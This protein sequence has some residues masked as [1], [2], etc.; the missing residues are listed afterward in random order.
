M[1]RFGAIKRRMT[2]I[3][4]QTIPPLH[5]LSKV[6]ASDS[7]TNINIFILPSSLTAPGRPDHACS[8]KKRPAQRSRVSPDP[9]ASA[10]P[11]VKAFCAQQSLQEGRR[12]GPYSDRRAIDGTATPRWAPACPRDK[13]TFS[14]A[15]THPASF[16]SPKIHKSAAKSRTSGICMCE[17]ADCQ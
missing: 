12:E 3:L 13:S 10:N 11:P 4:Q 2:C 9:D 5:V 17:D 6:M 1:S 16:I 15:G 8:I 7:S 14:T